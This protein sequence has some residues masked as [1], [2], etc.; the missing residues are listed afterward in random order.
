MGRTPVD[1]ATGQTICV[2]GGTPCNY[3]P[4]AG[5]AAA[6]N[7]ASLNGQ[8][9]VGN[10]QLCIADSAGADTGSLD[11]WSLGITGQATPVE[12]FEFSVE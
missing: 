11:Q 7:L 1:L 3:A 8:T 9:K 2:D 5:S 4:D 10:W 6:G 12:L